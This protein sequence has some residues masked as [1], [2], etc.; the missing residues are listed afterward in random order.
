MVPLMFL[1]MLRF[2]NCYSSK[3]VEYKFGYNFG[4]IFFDYSGKG[5]H[6]QNGISPSSTTAD[7]KPTD[8]GAFFSDSTS[9][10]IM[11]P[12]NS[13]VT[14]GLALGSTFSITMWCLNFDTR[15]YIY[16][17]RGSDIYFISLGR[18]SNGN[19]H[20]AHVKTI[21]YNSGMRNGPLFIV[22]SKINIDIWNLLSFV[23]VGTSMN[24]YVNGVL[25]ISLT[26]LTDYSEVGTYQHYIGYLS[27]Q[28]A[29]FVWNY[30][31]FDEVIDSNVYV[32]PSYTPGNCLVSTCTTCDNSVLVDGSSYC[33]S[34]N[35]QDNRN[36]KNIVCSSCNGY[37]CSD[38]ACLDCSA[39]LSKSCVVSDSQAVCICF[40]GTGISTGC[41]CPTFYYYNLT[42]FTCQACKGECGTCANDYSCLSCKDINAVLTANFSC[43]CSDGFYNISAL[44]SDGTCLSCHNDCKTCSGPDVCIICKD[45][46]AEI[47]VTGCK[48]L[49]QYFNYSGTCTACN[50]DCL[51]CSQLNICDYCIS[52]FANIDNNIGCKCFDGYYN[53]TSL[54]S[55]SSCLG[56]YSE[57][58]TCSQ[59]EKCISCISSNALPDSTKGCSCIQGYYNTSSLTSTS[60]CLKCNSDCFS[61]VDSSTCLICL[62]PQA[63][64]SDPGCSCPSNYYESF[65]GLCELCPFECSSCSSSTQCSSCYDPNALVSGSECVCI[66]S[67]FNSTITNLCEACQSACSS[68]TSYNL[69]LSCNDI[70]AVVFEGTCVCNTSYFNSS[71]GVCEACQVG[72]LKCSATDFCLLCKDSI[73]LIDSGLCICP[74]TYYYS[75]E[76]N[77]LPCD[78]DCLVCENSNLC[79]VCK[80]SHAFIQNLM[81]M[82]A[83]SNE[84]SC[85]PGYYNSSSDEFLTCSKCS[86][87]CSECL[88][89]SYCLSCEVLTMNLIEGICTCPSNSAL[90]N[91]NC[92]CN[93]GHYWIS[94]NGL[95]QC[96]KCHH[97]CLI[98]QGPDE[99]NCSL[100]KD[101][102]ILV[103]STCI[104]CVSGEYF[105]SILQ[106]CS[107]CG[108]RCLE[109]TGEDYCLSCKDETYTLFNGHCLI[110]A[111]GFKLENENCI[112]CPT[113]CTT[114]NE[115]CTSCSKNAILNNSTCE[116]LIGYQIEDSSCKDKFFYGNLKVYEQDKLEFI[117]TEPAAVNLEQKDFDI[118]L[119]DSDKNKID[120]I[121]LL[122]NLKNSSYIIGVYYTNPIILSTK[123][124]LK[125]LK[126][127]LYS[128]QSSR[129][130]NYTFEAIIEPASQ[131]GT[132]QYTAV[133]LNTT[134]AATKIIISSSLGTSIVSSPGATW[135][136]LNTI[137]LIAFLPLNSNPLTPSVRVFLTSFSSYNIAPN[138]LE[139]VFDPSSSSEPYLESRRF[140]LTTS[141][142]IINIGSNFLAFFILLVLWPLFYFLSKSGTNKLA[143]K[144]QVLHKGY[145]FNFFLRA[146]IQGYLEIGIYSFIQIRAV[147]RN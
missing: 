147:I 59:P 102:Y 82:F 43:L 25:G 41:T 56:C 118:H 122:K 60:S 89:S 125:L 45:T 31:V 95:Y 39:C 34:E 123:I 135:S 80:D 4:Q 24:F 27:D 12:P 51:S 18:Q 69:C 65:G 87:P 131:G 129:L 13:V 3:L 36:G 79:S 98:C 17:Y 84:C 103:N 10:Y 40:N 77:C 86:F 71:I 110:C 91:N 23:T 93:Q 119:N 58:A 143:V 128:S 67:Y 124:K 117:L 121:K 78:K 144:M 136:L 57:C 44:D 134:K 54:T 74:E 100:C 112:K 6:G 42:T 68:C 35:L 5:N 22:K 8:R 83:L 30:V 140:G 72:C 101:S 63:I 137:Q 132:N 88:T 37:G 49:S 76:G 113:L 21:N 97:S 133:I 52:D 26:L 47:D 85:D 1:F 146:L 94:E 142:F 14:S 138:L 114:C 32:G 62:D 130:F 126:K 92:N 28:L 19:K 61:C 139:Y 70:N 109:C 105:N 104:K 141:V 111:D 53:L 29:G 20:R 7:T 48:C 38:L 2:H 75:S 127:P 50:Q 106:K 81:F 145:I 108:P 16:T 33:I 11:L 90:I 96:G 64:P 120:S 46:Y 15:N 9:D 66:D 99:N 116:C 55:V 73:A 107:K 115:E